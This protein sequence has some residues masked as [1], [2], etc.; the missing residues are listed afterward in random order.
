MGAV[1]GKL[2]NLLLF[3]APLRHKLFLREY[4]NDNR[5]EGITSPKKKKTPKL[6]EAKI[7]V[8]KVHTNAKVKQVC[9]LVRAPRAMLYPGVEEG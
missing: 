4:T 1:Q 9:C 5:D 7:L 2:Q 6:T 3:F 8:V